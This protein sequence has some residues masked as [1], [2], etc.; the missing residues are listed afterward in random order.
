MKQI[1]IA[2]SDD[3][4]RHGQLIALLSTG[5]IEALDVPTARSQLK[6]ALEQTSI[7]S[8][9][10]AELGAT[11]GCL[12]VSMVNCMSFNGEYDFQVLKA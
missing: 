1:L 10:L 9:I 7:L 3:F 12:K 6:L 8:S 11:V 2:S 5:Y 4:L